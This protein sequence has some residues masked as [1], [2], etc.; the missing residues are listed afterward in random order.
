[1]ALGSSRNNSNIE[2]LNLCLGKCLYSVF[3]EIIKVTTTIQ[4]LKEAC[5]MY[6]QGY[7]K[8]AV[9]YV[10]VDLPA[11]QNTQCKFMKESSLN[12]H[13]KSL[14]ENLVFLICS[15]QYKRRGKRLVN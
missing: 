4:H 11:F 6:L 13:K 3:S 2:I 12:C 14:F 8:Y 9:K 5:Y 10:Y 7:V 15:F 1:M